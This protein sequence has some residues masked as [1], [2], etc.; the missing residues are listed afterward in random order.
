MIPDYDI[1][2]SFQDDY[3]ELVQ[4]ALADLCVPKYRER[5][6]SAPFGDHGWSTEI[7]LPGPSDI[8]PQLFDGFPNSE[9]GSKCCG[10]IDF[11]YEP[12]YR[13]VS[14][15]DCFSVSISGRT[16]RLQFIFIA[17]M[18]FR[19]TLTRLLEECGGLCGSIDFES[20]LPTFFWL[21]ETGRHNDDRPER[22]SD[23]LLPP[24]EIK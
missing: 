13:Y 21:P 17:S 20:L 1:R 7:C 5:I 6:L 3:K 2:L 8:S 24:A 22:S 16:S 14:R 10:W 4:K 11:C 18:Q 12:E 15:S 23:R 19:T 9:D